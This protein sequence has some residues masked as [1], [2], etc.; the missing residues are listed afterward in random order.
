MLITEHASHRVDPEA[1][2]ICR[3]HLQLDAPAF[4]D[5]LQHA[6]RLILGLPYSLNAVLYA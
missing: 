4:R 5:R 2:I 3:D 1:P 6:Q